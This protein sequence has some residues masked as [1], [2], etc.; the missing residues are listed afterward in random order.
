MKRIARGSVFR[1][2]GTVGVVVVASI[3]TLYAAG[4]HGTR[5]KKD[6][7]AT[8]LAPNAS[9]KARLVVKG[10]KHGKFSLLAKHLPGGQQF[11]VIVAG[12]KVGALTTTSGGTGK[13][14]FS[15]Q[16]GGKD[17][18]L[19]FDPRGARVIV[20][21]EGG[22]DVLEGE[23]PNG[24][25]TTTACCTAKSEDGEVE[26]EEM[27]PDECTAENGTPIG[28]PGGTAASCIPNPCSTTPPP[29]GVVCCTN[30]TGDDESE[31][32]C[33]VVDTEAACADEDGSVVQ[34][35]S[36][37]PNPC[38]APPPS[39]RTACCVPED[40]EPGA[41]ECKVLSSATCVAAGGSAVTAATC[42]PD[43]CGSGSG[44]DGGGDGGGGGGGDE[45]D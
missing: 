41:T 12:V 1:I 43:P 4:G 18:L 11:D 2:L 42:E 3:G 7:T 30:H 13:A 8:S 10:S 14:R 39:D 44:G 5:V 6:L 25:G 31:A 38:Q 34:A 20:R 37:D 35:D 22:D 15:T 9:G 24:D 17:A 19:G 33:D 32:Q 16:P 21:D 26:C 28:V 29:G 45:Q 23:I 40:D 36:C 27:T